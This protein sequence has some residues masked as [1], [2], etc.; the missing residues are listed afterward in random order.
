MAIL[1]RS[2]RAAIAKA[3]KDQQLHLAWGLGDGEWTTPPAE[4][5]LATGLM[6]EIGRRTA[7][8]AAFVVPDPAGEIVID[9]A[10]RFTRS[11]TET[12]QLFIAFKFDFADAATSVIRE[13]GVFVGTITDPSLPAGKQYFLPS[14]LDDEGTLLQLEHK[15]PIYRSA[16]T[17]ETFEI[18]IT[19]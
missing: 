8:E 14:E 7:L 11:V 9:G 6:D 4:D 5:P 17:R 18:L 15:A 2:G 13:I 3:I 1:P 10:G 19:F 16:S 12:N